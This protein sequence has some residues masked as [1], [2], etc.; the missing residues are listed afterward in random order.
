MNPTPKNSTEGYTESWKRERDRQ[1]KFYQETPYYGTEYAKKLY[2]SIK[3]A[4]PSLIQAA[5]CGVSVS[6]TVYKQ[7]EDKAAML[8]AQAFKKEVKRKECPYTKYMTLYL[9]NT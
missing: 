8:L 4:V 1:M 9:F 3:K 7:D 5:V 2:D 6:L